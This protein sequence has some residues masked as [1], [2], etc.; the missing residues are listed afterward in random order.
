ME[1]IWKPILGLE[2]KYEISNLGN[3]RRLAY[4]EE[5]NNRWG[6]VIEYHFK[7]KTL[8][9][10]Y[11]RFGYQYYKIKNKAYYTHKLIAEAFIPNPLN[12]PEVDHI[13]TI[14][15]DNRI[16]NLRWVTD[17]ENCNNPITFARNRI[18]QKSKRIIQLSIDGRYIAEYISIK[19]AARVLDVA[20]TSLNNVLN[21]VKGRSTLKGYRFV[22]ASEYNPDKDYSIMRKRGGHEKWVYAVCERAVIKVVNGVVCEAYSSVK[23]ASEKMGYARSSIA[24]RCRTNLVPRKRTQKSS[25]L[26]SKLNNVFYLKDLSTELQESAKVMLSQ[27]S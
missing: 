25:D 8:I 27:N 7:P 12:K 2:G 24:Q 22:Y 18:K 14:R 26:D 16:E 5:R 13:N 6:K 17:K 19:E 23:E 1:E 9:P 4:T 10:G 20:D 11:T 15:D 21:R 3:C